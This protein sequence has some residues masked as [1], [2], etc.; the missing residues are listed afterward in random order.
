MAGVRGVGT[1]WRYCSHLL[2][3]NLRAVLSQPG[4]PGS[5]VLEARS[6]GVAQGSQ[7]ALFSQE[8]R[9]LERLIRLGAEGSAAVQEVLAPS[10]GRLAGRELGAG[11]RLEDKARPCCRRAVVGPGR[12]GDFHRGAAAAGG[13]QR[14]HPCT[15]N[16]DGQQN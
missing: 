7:M 15:L 9:G 10:S 4:G 6:S 8:T 16:R 2:W 14:F 5:R 1:G 13:K 11:S 12:V 3:R